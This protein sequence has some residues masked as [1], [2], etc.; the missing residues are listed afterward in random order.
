[1]QTDLIFE[2][3]YLG[4]LLTVLPS[5]KIFRPAIV[6]TELN[7]EEKSQNI[8]RWVPEREST[9]YEEQERHGEEAVQ[10]LIHPFCGIHLTATGET[11]TRAQQVCKR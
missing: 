2:L 4:Y 7:R 6:S 8:Y 10:P 9:A 1:M 11:D 3:G 5:V